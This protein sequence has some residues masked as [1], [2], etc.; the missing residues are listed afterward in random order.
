MI[1]GSKCC[2][3]QAEIMY[4]PKINSNGTIVAAQ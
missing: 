1:D 2:S 4:N 3:D